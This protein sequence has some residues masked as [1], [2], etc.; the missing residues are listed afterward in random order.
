M[1]IKSRPI[2]DRMLKEI[3]AP[4]L[5]ARG[6][7]GSFPHYRRIAS[8]RIDLI[9]FQY[10]RRGGQFAVELSQCAAQGIKTEWGEEIPPT[11][12][13]VHDTGPGDRFRLS[14]KWGWRGKIFVF[15]TPSYDPPIAHTEAAMEASCTKAARLA[16][17]AFNEQAE[18]WWEQKAASAQ[19]ARRT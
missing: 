17:K 10:L 2:M 13:T 6:F 7:I 4:E 14:H 1:R 3:F 15:D 11:N 9:S 8:G 16:L 5:R 12:V 18:R 19:A